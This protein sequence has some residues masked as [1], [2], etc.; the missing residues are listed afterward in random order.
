MIQKRKNTASRGQ[1]FRFKRRQSEASD[2]GHEKVKQK[3][4]IHVREVFVHYRLQFRRCLEKLRDEI[5]LSDLAAA[6]G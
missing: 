1:R 5:L 6:H 4:T 2:I 3:L